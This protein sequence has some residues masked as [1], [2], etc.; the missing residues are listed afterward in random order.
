[1]QGL[2][3]RISFLERFP[4]N[5][6]LVIL[7]SILLIFVGALTSILLFTYTATINLSQENNKMI[8]INKELN[9]III[10]NTREIPLQNREMLKDLSRIVNF[11][12]D[13]FNQSFIEG[14]YED[15]ARTNQT[16]NAILK[17]QELMERHA[18]ATTDIFGS[19]SHTTPPQIRN[20]LYAVAATTN[21]SPTREAFTIQLDKLLADLNQSTSVINNLQDQVKNLTRQVPNAS[22]TVE[23]EFGTSFPFAE[24]RI[25]RTDIPENES[26]TKEPEGGRIAGL[27]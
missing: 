18:N 21:S 26:L 24:N 4:T 20:A 6:L 16:L 12:G 25:Q 8:G 14:I 17:S 5:I 15:R 11:L 1:M 10:N 22:T 27:P 19:A 3:K 9:N 13:N 23:Q 2:S 7:F